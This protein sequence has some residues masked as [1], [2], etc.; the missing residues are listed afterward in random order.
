MILQ[1]IGPP[2]RIL[3]V[4]FALLLTLGM[5]ALLNWVVS[6]PTFRDDMPGG[7]YSYPGLFDPP[8]NAF[9]FFEPE[10]TPDG[11]TFRWTT[12]HA[13]ITF[14][15]AANAGRHAR[16]ALRL[17]GRPAGQAPAQVT[18]LLNGKAHSTFEVAGGY[19]VYAT[20]LDT[21]QTPN[22][23]LDPAHVQIDIASTTSSSPQDPRELGVAVDWIEVTPERSRTEVLAEGIAWALGVGVVLLM[24]FARLPASWAIVYGGAT[25][26]TLIA[27]HLTY[28]P[29]G[30][31][32]TVESALAAFGWLL[33]VA[34]A[35]RS[36]PAWGLALA[37]CL[38]WMVVAG[39]LLGEWQIDD[40]YITYR[41]AWNLAHGHGL[42]Y[43]V[44]ETAVEGYTTFLWAL[45]SSAAIAL[46]QHPAA[47]AQAIN[48]ALSQ[49]LLALAYYL[50]R[51]LTRQSDGWPLAAVLLL[52]VDASLL[53][54]GPKGSGMETVAFALLVLIPIALLWHPHSPATHS[55]LSTRHSAL[56][57]AA[58][59]ALG[60]ASLTRPE[61]VL[62][63]IV[64]LGMLAWQQR[65]G[66]R[67]LWRLLLPAVLPYLAIVLP[68]HIWRISFY[69]YPFP[70]TFYAKTGLSP[71]LILRGARYAW[72]FAASHWFLVLL[73]LIA[74]ALGGWTLL[75]KR[76]QHLHNNDGNR[77]NLL[78]A[79][80]VLVVVYAL[81]IV[82]AG[83]DH[84][85]GWRFFVP[86][87]APLALLSQE[88]GRLVLQTLHTGLSQSREAGEKPLQHPCHSERSEESRPSRISR[89]NVKRREQGQADA[90]GTRFFASLRMTGGRG[91]AAVLAVAL[92]AYASYSLW[93][94][95]P[96][97]MVGERTRR[98]TIA[99][100]RWGSAA[101][102]LRDNTPPQTVTAALTAGA[103]AYY[104]D[105][106][107]IDMLGLN[108]LHIGH[109]EVET[110]GEAVAGHEKRD[111]AYVLGRKP[112][113]ILATWED[114][115]KPLAGQI[116]S[117]YD[118][119]T[120]SSPT[121]ALV[122]WLR[123]SDMSTP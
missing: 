86:L 7:P 87:L 32:P 117:E 109:L 19:Q 97:G 90:R 36:R 28:M 66:G 75:S 6:P 96:G 89:G 9:G 73:A 33:A 64:L 27:M 115:F 99:L 88:G 72:E 60:L 34:L 112:D 8:D 59:V 56:R 114:Y 121:G 101:L 65:A 107:V 4:A 77:L 14:P 69:G 80:A 20:T 57:V 47:V 43:N 5:P 71:A 110:I 68:Y 78:A 120:V 48:I 38:L 84:F 21:T 98:E 44:G 17:G 113:Y 58:G 29:R 25:L 76:K 108:D 111:P 39:R 23:N 70:N 35:P 13:S 46:G 3:F 40:A 30:V 51:R 79:L 62:V 37:A 16:I 100:E 116:N 95:T 119:E 83:G 81:Y 24:G 1:G 2:K 54:Y 18:L 92:L 122:K 94:Q 26:A 49:C 74:L 67:H 82:V 91:V 118:Y 93:L 12:S 103:M 41:Y 105:R 50:G 85:V 53:V 123:R 63:A 55:A 11:T 106:R 102:W 31:N 15:L 52:A 104:S 22:P 10:T 42:I 45:L 61:G